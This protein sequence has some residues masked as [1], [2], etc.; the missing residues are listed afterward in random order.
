MLNFDMSLVNVKQHLQ[1]LN[2]LMPLLKMSD[3]NTR[4]LLIVVITSLRMNIVKKC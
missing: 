1:P 4:C 2:C 3:T